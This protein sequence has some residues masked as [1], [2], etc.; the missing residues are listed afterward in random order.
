MRILAI[1][2]SCDETAAA[3]VKDG[4]VVLSDP[5]AS[6][7]D[8]HR[9]Y[10]GV[11]PELASRNHVIDII[12]V[13]KEALETAG[14]TWEEIDAIA[15]TQGP[16]LVGALLVGL[17]SAQTLGYLYQKPVIPVHHLAGHLHAVKLHRPDE[18]APPIPSNHYVALA[19]SGGHT[20]IYS[21]TPTQSIR[22]IS[23]TRD[24]AA[25][26]AFDK[27]ARMLGLGYPGGPIIEKLA[28]GGDPKAH[29]FTLPRFKDGANDFSFSGLKTAV[30]TKLKQRENPQTLP[31][32][33]ERAD[34]L[35]SFQ[36]AVIAQ[37]TDRLERAAREENAS[38][39]ILAG[40]VACNGALRA[41]LR[42]RCDALGLSLYVARPRW[43]TDN[44]AMIA[45]A[46]FAQ[47]ASISD[48]SKFDPNQPLEPIASWRLGT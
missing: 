27:V 9:K 44:A 31:E 37:L 19:V 1:E 18:P 29:R 38:D 23:N 20:A 35:A 48:L 16:G 17:Q 25:G 45:G 42:D 34:L 43:C 26:E 28:R 8:V 6:Q 33:Q 11:V 46:A 36:F 3:I 21:E 40:G 4:L 32:G 24:D 41:H 5:I 47:L 14:C 2:T 7:I 15:V 12:P 30:L 13:V 22:Q 39:V 10:G